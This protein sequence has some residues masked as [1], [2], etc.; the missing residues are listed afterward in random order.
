MT[1]NGNGNEQCVGKKLLL[2]SFSIS[3]KK[4]KLWHT[5]K[6]TGTD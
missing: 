6:E 2:F 4:R 3:E 5:G 1:D